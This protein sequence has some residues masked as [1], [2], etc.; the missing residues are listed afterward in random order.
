MAEK[1]NPLGPTGEVVAH[2]IRRLRDAA[3]LTYAELGRRLEA[4][5]RTIPTLG[6]RK[7]ESGERRVDADDLV[8]LALA[9]GVTPIALLMPVEASLTDAVDVTVTGLKGISTS[10]QVWEWLRGFYPI[11]HPGNQHEITPDVAAFRRASFPAWA[12]LEDHS[13]LNPDQRV[14]R[15]AQ[16]ALD[17]RKLAEIVMAEVRRQMEAARGDD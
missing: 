13:G 2:N 11:D 7:I 8:A 9:L 14:A 4:N 10:R 17:E 16:A 12:V 15:K 6:L 3:N 1:K 5:G